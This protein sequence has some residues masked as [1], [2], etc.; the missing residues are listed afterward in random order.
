MSAHRVPCDHC[1][2][3]FQSVDRPIRCSCS[4]TSL[5]CA[6]TACSGDELGTETVLRVT[7]AEQEFVFE[8]IEEQPVPSLLRGFSAPVHISVEG[9]TD[10]DL[11]LLLANDTG[12]HCACCTA[13][14]AGLS[15]A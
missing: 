14:Q 2:S 11:L 9:Q 1:C 5:L 15:V 4:K 3:C 6:S 8:G 12:E 13:V 10:G 7:E